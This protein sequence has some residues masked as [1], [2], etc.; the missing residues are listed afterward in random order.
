MVVNIYGKNKSGK[1]TL[2][3][4]LEREY[5]FVKLE[6]AKAM[7]EVIK[8][9][10]DVDTSWKVDSN[11]NLYS[12]DTYINGMNKFFLDVGNDFSLKA[13]FFDRVRIATTK[14]ECYRITLEL[15]GTEVFRNLISKDIWVSILIFNTIKCLGKGNN[16]VIDDLRFDNE[17]FALSNLNSIFIKMESPFMEGNNGH[18]SQ[19]YIDSFV[20]DYFI[21]NDGTK[22]D[23]LEKFNE[24]NIKGL[25]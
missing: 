22:E 12:D 17:Y 5:G 1:T 11:W 20:Y 21:N 8:I 3:N 14:Y 18:E 19:K 25:C 16:V 13:L 24:F 15:I 7:R 4:I 6:F 23:L 10:F 9:Y 2:A